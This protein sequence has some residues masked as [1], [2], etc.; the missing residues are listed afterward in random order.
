MP[1]KSE[2]LT[3]WHSVLGQRVMIYDFM[4]NKMVHLLDSV[5]K[6]QNNFGAGISTAT[7]TEK[8]LIPYTDIEWN[9]LKL[10]KQQ[11]YFRVFDHQPTPNTQ[12][13]YLDE[14]LISYKENF[15][16]AF[17]HQRNG[18]QAIEI[19]D[20]ISKDGKE[21][22]SRDEEL[23]KAQKLEITRLRAKV[24]IDGELYN[25]ANTL[26]ADAVR[27]NDQNLLP[28]W[29]D[30]LVLCILA[31]EKDHNIQW[32]ELAITTLP[33]ALRY[34]PYKTKLLLAPV[35]TFISTFQ[36]SEQFAG[37]LMRITETVPIKPLMMWLPQLLRLA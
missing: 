30:W 18:P 7:A 6:N 27:N 4:K 2:D 3:I 1:D 24:L 28:L 12:N 14:N 13:L 35:F 21:S 9:K 31:Y 29:R 15:Y 37:T 19:L 20:S 17:L 26:F 10:V 36:G 5:V 22:A 23:I 25:E 34:K 8:L 33:Y 16:N 32:A 11:R